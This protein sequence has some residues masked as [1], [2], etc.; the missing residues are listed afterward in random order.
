MADERFRLSLAAL[1]KEIPDKGMGISPQIQRYKTYCQMGYRE[2][3]RGNVKSREAKKEQQM[4]S[5]L[6]GDQEV[7]SD[8]TE[9]E[10]IGTRSS[11]MLFSRS[12]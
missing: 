11:E 6:V 2:S 4:V 3:S 5:L 1:G 8:G 12:G 7:S 9:V 10:W